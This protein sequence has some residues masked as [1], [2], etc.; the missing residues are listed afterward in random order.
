M[1][2]FALS[3]LLP[4]LGPLAE[5]PTTA[6]LIY[7]VFVVA[8]FARHPLKGVL[9]RLSERAGVRL[10]VAFW[11]SGALT[12]ALAWL[13]NYVKRAAEP[14][15]FH[16]QLLADLYLGLG[17]YG[18]WAAVWALLLRWFPFSPLSAFLTTGALG[19]AFEQLG[20]VLI[21]IIKAFPGRP[22]LALLMGVYVFLVHGSA[23]GLAFILADPR[24][25]D[26]RAR[27][28]W[29]YPLAAALLVGGA[30]AGTAL[31]AGVASLFGGLPP[32]GPI[33]ERPFW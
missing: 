24:S 31:A 19:I 33:V 16:P 6:L 32:K 10:L 26:V 18:G 29:Q 28:W 8:W 9:A 17:F 12:E 7:T 13:D 23:A 22:G 27:R 25:P 1:V 20:A 3:G 21:L 15:L 5:P 11:V 14:A 30:W 4:L 2:L